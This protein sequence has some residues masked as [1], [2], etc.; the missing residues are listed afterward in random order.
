MFSKFL[1]V[2]TCAVIE[3]ANANN[4]TIMRAMCFVVASKYMVCSKRFKGSL[5]KAVSHIAIALA[6]YATKLLLPFD[7]AQR[8]FFVEPTTL[9]REG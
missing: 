1:H 5:G 3:L 7:M 4:I 9:L 6:S 8:S 2:V